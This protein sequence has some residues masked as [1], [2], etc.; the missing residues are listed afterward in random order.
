MRPRTQEAAKVRP[1]AA[2][3]RVD[4]RDAS[5]APRVDEHR[6]TAARAGL[7]YVSDGVAGI[8]RE[9]SGTGWSYY[10]PDGERITDRD[11]LKRIAS[12]VVPPAWTEVWI[13]PDTKGHIQVTARDGRGRKQYRYHP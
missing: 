5:Q 3:R 9:R 1:I 2:P 13:C 11:E 8:R 6:E 4:L 12:L 7:T 10:R